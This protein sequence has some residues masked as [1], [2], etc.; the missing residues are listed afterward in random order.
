M[1][2]AG[3]DIAAQ[4]VGALRQ[5]GARILRRYA[6]GLGRDMARAACGGFSSPGNASMFRAM[7][8]VSL[9]DVMPDMVQCAGPCARCGVEH[10]L[11]VGGALAPARAL[12]ERL[13]ALGRVDIDAPR[14]GADPRFAL[15]YLWGEA[16]GQMFGVLSYVDARGASGT[17][18]AFS[19]QYNGAWE[20]P[21]W[22]PP[23]LDV[24]AFHAVSDPVE[25]QIKA[26]GRE[27]AA[28]TDPERRA[29][30]KR[31]RRAMSQGLMRDIHALYRLRNGA[32]EV[33]PMTEIFLAP[34]VPTGAG[35]CC[36]PKLLQHAARLGVRP[37]GIVEFYVGRENRS[38]TRRHGMS[39]A[40]CEG[41]CRP[42]LGFMLCGH[43]AVTNG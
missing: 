40:A 24:A 13:E 39:Y 26:I 32:G 25:P 41:K 16:R 1:G 4:V 31:R 5:A 38:G 23:V 42:L 11:P 27:M 7:P 20:V 30:L 14:A 15:D 18:R 28:C 10:G 34:G 36:A 33:R 17:L 9:C 3:E 21:G 29:A 43:A 12:F 2:F 19:G 22:T 37:T 8:T 35:D 6:R